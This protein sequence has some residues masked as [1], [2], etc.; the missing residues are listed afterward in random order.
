MGAFKWTPCIYNAKYLLFAGG[1]KI[2]RS[3]NNVCY[4]KL[5]QSAVDSVQN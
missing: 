2:H 1:L 4:C 3:I 5:F